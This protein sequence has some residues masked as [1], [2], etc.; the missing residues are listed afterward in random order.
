MTKCEPNKNLACI[1]GAQ[2][3]GFES[4][5]SRDTLP[6]E[7]NNMNHENLVTHSL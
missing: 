4:G 1:S 2:L 5:K 7:F 6:L 3:H